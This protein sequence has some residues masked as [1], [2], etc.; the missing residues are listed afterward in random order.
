M[1]DLTK[2][3]MV[4]FK[5]LLLIGIYYDTTIFTIRKD[6]IALRLP[7]GLLSTK[8]GHL[9]EQKICKIATSVFTCFLAAGHRPRQL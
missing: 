6:A 4:I 9:H 7:R 3:H 1:L 2:V 8:I 5:K